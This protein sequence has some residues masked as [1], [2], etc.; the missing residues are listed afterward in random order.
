[1]A[2]AAGARAA[3][4]CRLPLRACGATGTRTCSPV[5]ASM[6]ERHLP[7]AGCGAGLG[8]CPR[9]GWRSAGGGK[10]IRALACVE[11]T[12]SMWV[13]EGPS[14]GPSFTGQ[15]TCRLPPSSLAF[16]CLAAPAPEDAVFTCRQQLPSRPAACGP[17]L[18]PVQSVSC[19]PCCC[20]ARAVCAQHSSCHGSGCWPLCCKK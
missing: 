1:M 8:C 5:R 9:A 13:A 7:L 15:G 10:G 2:G 17:K 20:W 14:W 6:P 11:L 3:A 16:V 18:Q 12:A 19:I 4:V